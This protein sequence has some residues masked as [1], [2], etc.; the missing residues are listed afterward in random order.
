[1][2]FGST[3]HPNAYRGRV[4]ALNGN[5]IV[6]RVVGPGGQSRR[7]GLAVAIA[8]DSS[9]SGTIVSRPAGVSR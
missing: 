1:V 4:Q 5:R 9:L 3:S 8:E 7:L 2:T 6:A